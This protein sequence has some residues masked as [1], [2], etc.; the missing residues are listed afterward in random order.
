[1]F[2]RKFSP[3]SCTLADWI[4]VMNDLDEVCVNEGD[5]QKVDQHR[6]QQSSSAKES[7]S[8]NSLSD[9]SDTTKDDYYKTK[10]RKL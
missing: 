9:N 1:M 6:Q 7:S 3:D 10:K 4:A 2:A 8:L 5:V